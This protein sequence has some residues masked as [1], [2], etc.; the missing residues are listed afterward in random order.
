[1]LE[2]VALLFPP[3]TLEGPLRSTVPPVHERTNDQAQ[4]GALY[5]AYDDLGPSP[6]PLALYGSEIAGD[7]QQ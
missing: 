6:Q 5:A 4:Q 7:G 3:N 1:M 2:R